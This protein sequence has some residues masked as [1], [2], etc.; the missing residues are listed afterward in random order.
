MQRHSHQRKR[1]A[2]FALVSAV[3]WLAS[4]CPGCVDAPAGDMD[5]GGVTPDGGAVGIDDE[6]P[7]PLAADIEGRTIVSGRSHTC[8]IVGSGAVRC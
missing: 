4:G 8:A 7:T 3:V 6:D 5:A 2:F 1:L